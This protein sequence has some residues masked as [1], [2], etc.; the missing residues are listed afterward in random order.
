MKKDSFI[1]GAMI[2]TIGVILCKVIGLVY[3]IPF[4]AI[5]GVQG[6]AL[7]SYAYSIYGIFLSL[8][9]SGIPVA[10]SKVISEYNSLEYYNTKERTYKMGMRIIET[11]GFIFFIVLIL[12]APNIA[13]LI[14]GDRIAQGGNSIESV[15]FVIRVVAT[16]LLIVPRLSVTKGYLE[17][18]KVMTLPSVAN[19]LEQLVRVMVIL[20]GSYLAIK[21]FK[22]SLKNAVGIAVFGATIGALLAYLYL[23]LKIK[24]NKT[25]L[26]SNEKVTRKEAKITN[27]DIFKKIVFYALPFV[28]IDLL[29][30]AYS[31]VD[32]LTVVRTLGKLG[33]E[34]AVSDA[35]IGV[36]TTWGMKLNMIVTS[37]ATGLVISLIPN[38]SSSYVKKNM[39]DVS[40]KVNQALQVML[41]VVLPLVLV[42]SFLGQPVWI[43]FYGYNSVSVSMYKVFAFQA[44]TYSFFSVLINLMQSLSNPKVALTTLL[45][46]FLTKALI[47]VPMMYLM[48]KIGVSAYFGEIFATLI[49]QGGAAIYLLKKLNKVYKVDYKETANI[50]IKTLLCVAILFVSLKIVNLFITTNVLTRKGAIITIIIYGIISL[51][52]YGIVAL[53]SKLVSTV[54]GGDFI[55]SIISRFKKKLAK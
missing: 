21:V 9:N 51:I 15:S 49:A 53:K 24:K 52:V 27:Q 3:V 4:Y 28:L 33:Y 5:I 35:A 44:L 1:K 16:A 23:V 8:S 54:F 11:L 25:E 26:N 2:S 20:V 37:I 22:T 6:S 14:L 39:A 50:F 34:S 36:V 31:L 42:L 47:N 29:L 12:F 41:T 48:E 32:T 13:H 7:Y 46:T 38:I 19:V 43:I 55:N 45:F 18:H 40:K 30:S 17:G 10:M